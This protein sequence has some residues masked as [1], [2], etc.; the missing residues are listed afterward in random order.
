MALLLSSGAGSI[1][2]LSPRNQREVS[3]PLLSFLFCSAQH[4]YRHSTTIAANE[5]DVDKVFNYTRV[6]CHYGALVIEFRDAWRE[7]DGDRVVRCWRL[8]MPHFKTAGCSK[9]ALEA[10]RLQNQLQILSPNLLHQIKWHRFV[11]TR[12]GLGSNIPCD[13]YNEHVNK[14]VKSSSR[15][16]GQT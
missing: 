10:L 6:L 14:L 16:W 1:G 5:V 13:L 11:N 7:G 9:Y 3:M 8:L 12:G 4:H 2:W 15:T